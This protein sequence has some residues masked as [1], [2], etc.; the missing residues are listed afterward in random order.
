MAKLPA[1]RAA[2]VRNVVTRIVILVKTSCAARLDFCVQRSIL[3][4]QC[5]SLRRKTKMLLGLGLGL[6]MRTELSIC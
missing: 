4:A 6:R 2:R 5:Y 1:F 3:R